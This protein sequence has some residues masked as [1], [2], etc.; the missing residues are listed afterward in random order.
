MTHVERHRQL[1]RR[2][3]RF[4]EKGLDLFKELPRNQLNKEILPQ[5][6]RSTT[7]V[8]AIYEEACGAE[9]AKDFVHKFKLMRKEA[10]ET[11]YWFRLLLRLN[12][13]KGKKIIDLGKE[14]TELIKI[15]TS[16][17]SKFKAD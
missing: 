7:A 5:A 3:R 12:P 6:I 8:G 14:C 4:V 2:I 13:Q 16:I 9:S 17:I 11:R 10:R 1:E 15:F